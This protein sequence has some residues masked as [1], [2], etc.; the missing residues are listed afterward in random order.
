MTTKAGRRDLGIARVLLVVLT[1]AFVP[2]MAGT[3]SS[4]FGQVAADRDV[5]LLARENLV[6]WCI[7][8]F[9]AGKRGPAERA[10]MLKELGL[11]RCAYDWREE[12]VPTFEQEI[13]EYRKQGIEYFA[14][15]AVHEEAFKLFEKYQ[16][17]P[18]IWQT[19]GEPN[20]QG[21]NEEAKV[22][23]AA[24]GMVPLARRTKA[25]GSELGLYNHG[26][27]GGEPKNLVAVC[28]RLRDLGY[29]NVGIVYNFHHGHGHISDWKPS[30][31]LM[32][33][34][35]I[36]LNLNGMNP[37]EQPKILGIGK[38]Q[39]ELEMI[40]VVVESGYKGPIGII[41]HREQLD[42]RE[43]L[44]E[45]LEGVDWVRK[46]LIKPGS[47]GPRPSST[48]QPLKPKTAATTTSSARAIV[49][50]T[51]RVHE[52]LDAYRHPPITVECRATLHRP[53][54]YN[55]L[56]ASDTK[57]S[58]THWELFSM[59]GSGRLTAYLPGYQ[60][61]HVQA[62]EAVC[63]GLPHSLA[64]ILEAN[65]VRLFV[66]GRLV[67]D[68]KTTKVREDSVP[69]GLAI[70]RLV[71]G[72]IG[73]H[74]EIDWVRI[75][76][77]VREIPRQVPRTVARDDSSI[78]FWPEP[79]RGEPIGASCTCHDSHAQSST[80]MNLPAPPY[81]PS[82]VAGLA[83]EA[84]KLGD[85]KRGAEIFSSAGSAC[86]SCHKIGA[87][88]GTVG[89]DLTTIGKQT[90]LKK[91]VESVLWPGREVKPEF[92]VWRIATTDGKIATGYKEKSD[93]Q[94]VVLRDPSALATLSI[95]RAQ[96][97]EEGPGGSLM[98]VGLLSAMTREQQRDLLRFLGELGREGATLP[99]E[100]EAVLAQSQSH[101]PATF[102]FDRVPLCPQDWP[103]AG[104]AINRDRLYDFYTKQAEY[105]RA[106]SSRPPLL[107]QFPGL[108]GGAFGHWGNQSEPDWADP[109][110]NATQLGSVQCGVFRGEGK[111]IPRG[112]CV[113][114]GDRG[115]LS[116]CFNPET[117]TYDAVWS[118]G[119]VRF[120][121]VRHGFVDGLL[122]DGVA[123]PRPDAKSPTQP[124]IYRGYY[125]HGAR[126]VFAYRIGETEYLDAPWVENG[127]FTREVAPA[128]RHSSRHLTQGGPAQW[129]QTIAT[130]IRPG[131]GR[132]Y[133]IDTIEL[134]VENPWNALLFCGGHDFLKDGSAL[135]CTI[136][137]DVWHVS[138]LNSAPDRQGVATWRRFASGLHHALGLVVSN[139]EIYV[140]CRDQLTRLRDVDNDGEADFY[141]CF[142]NAFQTS[143]AG[144][145]FICGLE[146]DAQGRFY[147]ASGNQGLLRI[148]ADGRRAD[149]V[150]TGFRNPDG[151][152]VLPDGTV[153]LP[154]SEGE[155]TAASMICAVKNAAREDLANNASSS[156]PHFGYRGPR[157]GKPP[158][159]PLVYLPRGLD[160]S[161]GGQ[162][163]IS[164]QSWGPLHGQIVHLSHGAASHFLLLRDEV[165]GQPQ[166]AV[167]PL[168]GDFLSGVHRGRFHPL[169][170]QLYVSGLAGWGTYASRDGCFQRVRYTGDPVQLPVKFHVHENGVA[171]TF[172]QAVDRVTAEK[173]S[174]QFAQAWNYRYSS[175][176]GSPEYSPS[177]PSIPGHDPL[178]IESAHVL[179]DGRTVFFEIPEIQPV[180]QLHLRLRV[181]A[182]AEGSRP[183]ASSAGHDL[184][185]T[186]HKLD[187]PFRDFPG[188]TPR[189][190]TIAAHPLLRDL[191]S[192]DPPVPNPWTK[193]IVGARK[194][195]I[196]TGKNL[197]FATKELHVVAG[198]SIEFT[199]SN[200]D[201]VP[202][203]WALACP[204]SLQR[205]G[206]Q[207]NRLISDPR[208]V[209][210]QYIPETKEILAYTDVVAPGDR[211]TVYFRAPDHPGR[212]PYLCTF[213]GHW[214]V[215][216][217][218]MIV[219][220][221][222]AESGANPK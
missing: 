60:P 81:D 88:G 4:V 159:L 189:T 214:M 170:G 98:P 109:R 50:A 167:V 129:P 128:S 61:E 119:F 92:T 21:A 185:L 218:V 41:D 76:R 210:R 131:S 145:D 15:W 215:M 106:Q 101:R 169:D 9:D 126:V 18:Q 85:A 114:L 216:N 103:N 62:T 3:F 52:G 201:V 123:H 70:G 162:T 19:L 100:I 130:T 63:D 49:V 64:M 154:C 222:S 121:P 197:T 110:W 29:G 115:E 34:Y 30:F 39:H 75:S 173:S 184:F 74:G 160:N 198:E 209:A 166:G 147:T 199:L 207:A 25:M 213:P 24:Q 146:R 196:E 79:V 77:G 136:Q 200:P 58:A 36:C 180:S 142:S 5:K 208:A 59:A 111:T 13:L 204:D 174:L 31:E 137:G 124:F 206:E 16:L 176:Y 135:V 83:A 155:W 97:E 182:P 12:H 33:P 187:R 28:K 153:T 6:A 43:S 45:N 87:H 20:V 55:I 56:V 44:Q 104:E 134:P 91:L 108:D 86:L 26:G 157:D 188:Y 71:E 179:A 66:D 94:Q 46:E 140:Q 105:F 127:Q 48:P 217:G 1:L 116:A 54:D 95:P 14:F 193:R 7:V 161:S 156:P 35:L 178:K 164:S 158:E 47:G 68:Q 219:E 177:H 144:H 10:A 69:G 192:T 190:K 72:G 139:G 211:F 8:P 122:M 27:W 171:V 112:V 53:D 163:F 89:P 40:R 183:D 221:G 212:Y 2:P 113:R 102:P 186:V 42:A 96:I 168:P 84:S 107:S 23:A 181:E 220:P 195:E 150:A 133:A 17:H 90:E 149:V 172:T 194:I 99:R 73:F 82:L 132:P 80:T 78:G 152:C 138:G 202:H 117:L 22:E 203:N 120:S 175:A 32:R 141:E 151:L 118:G 57:A 38:G 191:A 65:R 165:D 37:G 125:R 205:V 51:G 143:P 67:G 11:Q 148:S 93:D